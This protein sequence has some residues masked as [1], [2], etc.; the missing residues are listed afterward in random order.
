MNYEAYPTGGSSH[1]LEKKKFAERVWKEISKGL[2]E[3]KD[4][5]IV[6]NMSSK[7]N[8]ESFRFVID[9]VRDALNIQF[10][11]TT[12]DDNVQALVTLKK[13]NVHN[14]LLNGLDNNVVAQS[15][16]SNDGGHLELIRDLIEMAEDLRF[17]MMLNLKTGKTTALTRLNTSQRPKNNALLSIVNNAL[18]S[19]EANSGPSGGCEDYIPSK[20]SVAEL[21]RILSA[22]SIVGPCVDPWAMEA[23][24]E[25]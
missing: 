6:K 12:T 1:S 20:D 18:R 7:H 9:S 14:R 19:L 10:I 21:D 16:R 2:N 23:A 11:P 25:E 24:N 17:S 22:P 15:R 8:T 5:K 3:D 4:V 13:R